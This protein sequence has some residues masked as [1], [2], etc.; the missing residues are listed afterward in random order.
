MIDGTSALFG[1]EDEFLVSSI[2]RLPS[3]DERNQRVVT[4]HRDL[5]AACPA[6]GC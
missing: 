3:S 4:E 1:M 6:W 2:E 5:E